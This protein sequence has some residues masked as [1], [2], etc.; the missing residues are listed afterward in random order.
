MNIPNK[1]TATRLI[2]APFFAVAFYYGHKTG[3]LALMIASVAIYAVMELTDLLDGVIARR[4]NMITDLGK[5]MDPFADTISHITFFLCFFAIGLMPLM[6]LLVILWREF[7]MSFVRM[8]VMGK[9][10]A[11]PANIFGK[12]KTVLY[13]I[14]S[15][16]SIA[17]ELFL[18]IGLESSAV[19]ESILYGLF[20][21]AAAA[22]LASF[23][24]Y[25]FQ[26]VKS[27]Y[28]KGMTH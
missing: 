22:S 23:V 16:L 27:G 25:I 7:S 17:Y 20:Y 5:V 1:L 11:L 2:L 21:L 12:S 6:A 8:L 13:A 18:F 3:Y 26:V 28:L 10:K 24:I 14:C 4:C 15:L 9:G 19:L